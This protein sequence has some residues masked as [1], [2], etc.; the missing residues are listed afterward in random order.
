V[1]KAPIV[2]VNQV[3]DQENHSKPHILE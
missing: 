1:N 2:F 3:Q